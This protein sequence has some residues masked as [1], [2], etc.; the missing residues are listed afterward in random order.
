MEDNRGYK[1][2]HQV[3]KE[4]WGYDQFRPV[5]EDMIRAVL[6]GKDTLGLLPTGGGKSICFQV[7]ALAM[8]GICVVISPLIALMKDQVQNLVKRKINAKAIVSG[9]HFREIDIVL[10]NCVYGDVKFLYLSPERLQSELVRVR[11]AKMK[12]NLLAV[13]E[14]HCI[15]QWGYDFRPNYLKIAEIRE[16]IPNVPIM[17]LTATA[18]P[19]VVDDIQEKLLFKKKNVF[20]KSFARENLTY[21]C[22]PS[23]NKWDMCLS[24]A[25]KYQNKTGIIYVRNRK[26]TQEIANYLRSLNISADY[27]HGGLSPDERSKKQDDWIN[28]R[29]LIVVATN[30]FG[31]GI[32]KPDVRFVIHIDLP[33]SLE[34]YFQEAGRGGRDLLP[35]ISIVIH[36]QADE[37]KLL[38]QIEKNFPPIEEIKRVYKALGNYFQL[39]IGSGIDQS[40]SFDLSDFSRTYKFQP[41]LVIASLKIL[42]NNE[43]IELTDAIDFSARLKFL[44]PYSELYNFYVTHQKFEPFLQTILRL[45]SGVLDNYVKIDEAQIAGILKISSKDVFVLLQKLQKQQI[46]EYIPASDKPFIIYKTGR[47]HENSLRISKESYHQRKALLEDK[48]KSVINFTKKEVCR[49]RLLLAYFGEMHT[50]NCGSC[51]VCRR[52][53]RS[54]EFIEIEN[55]IDIYLNE[56]KY[57]NIRELELVFNLFDSKKVM[58]IIRLR[59]DEE[60]YAIKDT[61]FLYFA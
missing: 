54:K 43:Y 5:Q 16:I 57:L 18:T 22:I 40:Y 24:L 14:A 34:A 20:Q 44:I 61:D 50:K 55:Q 6:D 1:D 9:M 52:S 37:N 48:I 47:Q 28:N 26:K 2:I 35:A 4:K 27:Y 3:L 8:P 41:I 45:Y 46:L 36:N 56:N 59:I 53:L 31:M 33:D 25:K 39:A 15:S 32:D 7:P 10:D 58:Q 49:S 12:I 17:A 42:E 60:K 19:E 11:L 13:D 30:A 51:D 29:T 23:D 38:E 21:F